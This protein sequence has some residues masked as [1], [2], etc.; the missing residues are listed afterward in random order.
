[1]SKSFIP[2]LQAVGRGERLKRDLTFDES[3]DC[4][5]HMLG[6]SA[7]DIQ[8]GA[9]LL[10]QRVK[11]E[12]VSEI[13]GF[14]QVIRDEFLTRIQPKVEN[15][16]DI[17]CPYNGKTKTAQLSPVVAL[18]L[19]AA[20][21]PSVL[22]G[23]EGVP[24]KTGVTPGA[25]LRGLGIAADLEPDVANKMI[26]QVGFGFLDIAQFAPS[27]HVFS[28]VRQQFGLRTVCNT[29]EKF[30]NPADALYQ[31]SGFFHVNYI[32]R[33]RTSQTGARKSWMIQGEEGSIEAASGR[34]TRIFGETDENDLTLAPADVGLAERERITVS[35][36]VKKHVA[37]NLEVISGT[38]G[39]A[40]DQ[41][42]LTVGT[43]LH[44][45]RAEPSVSHG[46]AKA[47]QLLIDKKVSAVF[48]KVAA[49]K[50]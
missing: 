5:R 25:V 34:R 20:G 7:S 17:A 37:I 10:T 46:Y 45:L 24:T 27:W 4:M 35:P 32:E 50:N 18:T 14:T 33:I 22:H 8:I 41:V 39:A 16:L 43:I 40:A 21:V 9:L 13:D 36:D 38:K 6:R 42:A 23:G 2:F 28:Q 47:Q 19:L 29:I 49:F 11:G 12:S 3:V 15:L 26:E 44:L 31:V 30:F 48:S 1:M